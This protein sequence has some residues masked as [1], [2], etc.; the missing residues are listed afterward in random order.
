MGK[1]IRNSWP[2]KVMICLMVALVTMSN[3]NIP[4][5][6]ENTSSV[7]SENTTEVVED[8][9]TVENEETGEATPEPSTTPDVVETTPSPD[10]EETEDDSDEK[11]GSTDAADETDETD[12]DETSDNAES[13]SEENADDK[14]GDEAQNNDEATVLADDTAVT[15]TTYTVTYDAG[16]GQFENGSKTNVVNYFKPDPVVKYSHTNNI[17]D[18]GTKNGNYGNNEKKTEV[19]TI[20]GATKLTVTVKY[21]GESVNYDWVSVFKGNHPEY[22]ASDYSKA[23]VVQKL[24]GG[25]SSSSSNTK[26]YTVYSDSVT[27]AWR[28]DSSACGDGYGYYATVSYEGS[29]QYENYLVPVA[30]E[31]MEFKGWATTEG[32]EVKYGSRFWQDDLKEGMEN[33]TLY[34]VYKNWYETWEYTLDETEHTILLK[35]FNNYAENYEIPSTANINGVTYTVM[36]GNWGA[37]ENKAN[38]NT[39]GIQNLSFQPGIKIYNN[40]LSS[41]FFAQGSLYKVDLTN[42]DT[43]QVTDMSSMFKACYALKEVVTTNLDTSN[44]TDMSN[45]FS[46]CQYLKTVDVSNFDTSKVTDMQYMFN[47]CYQLNTINVSNFDTSNVTN[48]QYMFFQ[49]STI[50]EL[51]VSKFNTEKVTDMQYMFF[52]CSNVEALDV[53]NFDTSNVTSMY[54]M[55]YYCSK[56]AFLD[57]SK[58][59]TSKVTNM[60]G[61]FV[62]CNNLTRIKLGSMIKFASNSCIDETNS[63]KYTG[64]WKLN[65]TEPAIDLITEYDGS[66]PGTYFREVAPPSVTLS[67]GNWQKALDSTVTGIEKGAKTVEEASKASGAVRIDDSKTNYPVWAYKE[68]NK[69]FCVTDAERV[70]LP[71]D[72]SEWFR[73]G[74]NLTNIDLSLFD[75][76]KVTNMG[77][78][79]NSCNSLTS[80]DLGSF[81]TSAVT[82]MNYMFSSCGSLKSLNVSSFDTSTVKDMSYM[83]NGCYSLTSLD[84]SSFDTSAVTNMYYMFNNCSSLTSL[85]LSSFNT[86]AVTNM[87]YMFNYCRSL[88]TL[89]LGT[90]FA[91]KNDTKLVD[92][93][94]RGIKTNKEYTTSA[95]TSTYDGSTMADTYVKPKP[96]YAILYESGELVFQRG[97]TPDASKG[98]VLKTYTGFETETYKYGGSAPW[99]ENWASIKAVSFK[100]VIKPVSTSNWFYSC[101]NVTAIDCTNLDTS[102]VTNMKQMFRDCTALTS[103]DL[104]S[105]NTS[106]VTDM[107]Y[108]FKNCGSLTS[109]DLNSFNTSAVTNMSEMF[110]FCTALTSLD[111]SSFDTSAVTDMGYMFYRCTALETLTLGTKFA[112]KGDTVLVDTTWHGINTGKE[113]TTSVLTSTYDGSTMADTYVKPKL[114]YA[115]LYESGELVFQ[116]GRTPDASKGKVLETYTG[117][118]TE[119]YADG[120]VPW[121]K[122]RASIK[123]VSFKDVIKP[124]STVYWFYNCSNVTAIDCTN[125][126]TSTVTNMYYMFYGC[127]SLKSLNLNSFDTSA[128]KDMMNMFKNCGS[129]TSLDLSSFNTSAVKNMDYM[130]WGCSS[131]KSLDLNSFD[132]SAVTGM[133]YM[134]YSCTALETLTLGTKFSFRGD[135]K[136]VDVTWHGINTGKEYTTS[137]LTSTYDGS[138]MADTYVKLKPAYAILYESGELVFQRGSTPDASKGKV[139]KTYTGFETKTYTNADGRRAPWYENKASIKAVSFKDAIKPISTAYWFYYCTKVTAIDCTNLDTSAVTSMYSMFYNCSSLKS[140]NVSSFNTSAVTNMYYMFSGCNA[141]TSLD[142]R[143]FNT[144]AVTNM[145]RMFEGCSSL[146][147]LDLSS[148][149]TSA[150]KDIG[151]MFYNCSSLTSL[152]LSSFNT[153]V[154]MGMD[155]MFYN[156]SSLINL[157]LSSF[158]TSAVMGMNY[159]FY[160]CSSL[161]SLDVS[162]FN[163]SAV[164]SMWSMFRGCS[165]LTSLDVSS[166]N[167]SAVTNMEG[168]FAGC[169][170]LTSLNVS[171]FNTSAV[172][173]MRGMF[174]GCKSLTSLDV[175]S[176]NTSAVTSMDD[177]FSGCNSLTSLDLSSFNTSVAKYITNMFGG[178]SDLTSLDLSSFDTSAVKDTYHMFNQCTALETLTLGTK[179][180]FKGDTDLVD[181]TW[182]GINTGKEYASSVLTSSTYD[183]STMADTYVKCFYIKF[184]AMGGKSSVSTKLGY[185]GIVFDSLPTAEKKDYDFVGWFTEK[186]GGTR[187]LV[188]QPI[189]QSTYY[190]QYLPAPT[191]SKENWKTIYDKT[192]TSYE[193][194]DKTVD[195]ISKMTGAVR[196]DDGTGAPVWAYKEGTKVFYATN[197]KKVYLPFDSSYWF[198]TD[199]DGIMAITNIDT[200]LFDASKV[201]D[202]SYMFAG[203][204]SLNTLDVSKFDTS[205]VTNMSNMFKKCSALTTLDISN[206]NTSACTNMT[207]LFDGCNNLTE[208]NVSSFVTDNVTQMPFMFQNCSKLSTIDVTQFKT[209]N[210]TAFNGMFAGCSSL[211]SLDVSGFDVSKAITVDSMF[212][213]CSKLTTL[214]VSKFKTGN[215]K[216]FGNM[217][218]NCKGLKTIDVSNF[219]THS[220]TTMY[221]MFYGCSNATELDVSK[222]NTANVTSMGHMFQNCSKLTTLDVTHFNTSKVRDMYALFYNC[223]NITTLDVSKFD[224]GEVRDMKAV[225]FGCSK[226]QALDVSHFDTH[227][228]TNMQSLFYAC[229]SLKELN[230]S[231]FDTS[232]VI[233]TSHMFSNCT[234][235]TNIDASNFNTAKV[236]DMTSMFNKCT[237]LTDL[238][239][240]GFTTTND[241]VMKTMLSDSNKLERLTLGQN[242]VFKPDAG[243]TIAANGVSAP[244]YSHNW[245]LNDPYNAEKARSNTDLMNTY[246]GTTEAGTWVW[247]KTAKTVSLLISNTVSGN[248]GDKS[249]DFAF[250][251]QFPSAL[252]N[253]TL[254]VQK[255][256][257]SITTITVDADGKCSFTLKHGESFAFKELTEAQA[258][259]IKD[260]SSYGISESDYSKEGYKTS[261][262][263]STDAEGNLEIAYVNQNGTVLPTGIILSGSGMTIIVALIIAL[264]WAIRKKFLK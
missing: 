1:K 38:L 189:T 195:E 126:D 148:F 255:N 129:L 152:D 91:F 79:F 245:T 113:Y 120:T 199:P 162:S 157:D 244:E 61:M 72:S 26:T 171:S 141:L 48:M 211:T 239:I 145:S 36:I 252:A 251:T 166:F 7:D 156:C 254:K 219:D 202:A 160:D 179:F 3:I 53:S 260:L 25:S 83:F 203:C 261:F 154:V 12:E 87:R 52:Q 231:S 95:L 200:S 107:C 43:S 73:K 35:K 123:A 64:K 49:C 232:N 135:T 99:Y 235:L 208:L 187:L 164:T 97:N 233:N 198:N 66:K 228:A 218:Y 234:N 177:M 10:T 146:I 93:T 175:S 34:A 242:F 155:Y 86:S 263:L 119:T 100:D 121:Y 85:D 101:S 128:V 84:V 236:K 75:T 168:M 194:S 151:W 127:S 8:G 191:L 130:F 74:V 181:A 196:I 138:T 56:V 258:N 46:Q 81:N 24:G 176:F 167:T 178:C 184:D 6:A 209:G 243:L 238:D 90:K 21:G 114:A 215:V 22:T 117:F 213:S 174:S 42:L 183:G 124:V 256:G 5:L 223:S 89:T 116:R 173:D 57:L 47:Q 140:L 17:S 115:I 88:E 108:M 27:F 197:A 69:L 188:N 230:V 4:V 226:L 2:W 106:A 9:A 225:F 110:S 104:S 216:N 13:A 206:F 205:N 23:D 136:L 60:S 163:T 96:A 94:W 70:Y 169:S 259:A 19:V 20:P 54:V 186:Q 102:A 31:A 76:S 246:D 237:S 142:L 153:S 224:T 182:H 33:I 217:F 58:F 253:A 210:V 137:V 257:G 227:N 204:S 212:H 149:D 118:E 221:A 161:K 180:L 192:V 247:E 170:S 159:M 131:L 105:F 18:D 98:K 11:A 16:D 37:G 41:L 55:F 111:I 62:C 78:M 248:L 51:D 139:L 109:L 132:T 30:P 165:A 122:N 65:N 44:V 172:T 144:S 264:G 29:L 147:N 241:T 59:D 103:L 133:S 185:K 150:V 77:N 220:A 50:T 262:K 92:A 214:D 250:V 82:S 229:S 207:R 45:M 143:S 240:S 71:A 68:G 63:N 125:L 15:G 193:K 40:S 190:A 201:T 67:K 80:L 158:N 222:F 14:A 134:F 112:F 28:S 249:K 39:G 32:G